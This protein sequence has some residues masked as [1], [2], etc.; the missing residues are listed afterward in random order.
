MIIKTDIKANSQ[1]YTPM[2]NRNIE[3]IIIHNTGCIASVDNFALNLKNNKTNGSA[4][5][6]IKGNIIRQVMRDSDKAW[7]VGNAN[8]WYKIKNSKATNTNSLSLE[9]CDIDKYGRQD[10]DTLETTGELVRS[11]MK[12]YNIDKDHVI[13]HYDVL[14]KK[15]PAYYVNKTRWKKLKDDMTGDDFSCLYVMKS[16][17]GRESTDLKS[18]HV[19]TLVPGEML[20]VYNHAGD[21]VNTNKGY[22]LTKRLFESYTIGTIGKKTYGRKIPSTIGEHLFTL[23]YGNRVRIYGYIPNGKWARTNKGYV[24]KS[25]LG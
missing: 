15:C 16:T 14:N 21:C 1:N 22:V 12:K 24:L 19:S 4:H 9:M 20:K 2:D 11:L 7:S 6:F 23:D 13:R 25:R 18:P 8:G 10:P 5:Y 3:W 17:Y